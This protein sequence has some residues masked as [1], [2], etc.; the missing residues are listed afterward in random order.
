MEGAVTFR[1]AGAAP[2]CA[3]SGSVHTFVGSCGAAA[4]G[5]PHAPKY[6]A[7]DGSAS[8]RAR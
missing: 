8:E 7:L 6:W 4:G 2:R 3:I 1:Q 5:A